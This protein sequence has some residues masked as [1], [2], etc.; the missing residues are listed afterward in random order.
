[1]QSQTDAAQQMSRQPCWQDTLIRVLVRNYSGDS[2]S[3]SGRG[4]SA[5]LGSI[6][7]SRV[8]QVCA[9]SLE[10]N[11]VMSLSETPSETSQ[12]RGLCLDLS[13][14]HV[15]EQGD[16]GS[17][18]PSPLEN[19]KSFPGT[20]PER[21][22][23]SSLGDDSFLFSDNVSLGESFNSTEVKWSIYVYVCVH[24]PII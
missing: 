4:D 7:S 2:G 23:T 8:E 21:E 15:L 13:Q 6:G 16:S 14:V 22:T 12:S 3:G 5:S 18:T 19:A 20:A 24:S 9:E 1:M 17:Q 11:E 10:E